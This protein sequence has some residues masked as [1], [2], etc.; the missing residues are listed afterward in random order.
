MEI[1]AKD[2]RQLQIAMKLD[3][4][5]YEKGAESYFESMPVISV[6][7]SQVIFIN[8]YIDILENKNTTKSDEFARMIGSIKRDNEKYQELLKKG[9][10][11]SIIKKYARMTGYLIRQL[12]KYN[13]LY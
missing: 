4:Y 9:S 3:D 7:D 10:K 5:N 1:T 13:K 12:E 11:S 8:D 6:I 2:L